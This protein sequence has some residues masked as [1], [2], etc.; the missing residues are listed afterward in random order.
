MT[1]VE[2]IAIASVQLICFFECR[3]IVKIAARALK[4]IFRI[5]SSA[6]FRG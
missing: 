4:P 3:P 5:W 1:I 2:K 6:P